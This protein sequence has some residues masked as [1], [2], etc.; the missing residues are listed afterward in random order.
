MDCKFLNHGIAVWYDQTVKPCCAWKPSDEWKTINQ[1]SN[2]NLASWHQTEAVTVEREKL[3]Q[4]QWPTGCRYCNVHESQGR[5]DSVRGNG[6]ISY[7][8]YQG[9]DITLEIRPGSTCN[10]A[11]QTCWPV[12][13]SRVAQ[14][15]YQAGLLDT[16]E[17]N[18]QRLTN[19]DF[20]LPIAKRVKSVTLL[21]GEPFYDKACR[22]FLKWSETHLTAQLTLFTNGSCIDFDFIEKYQGKIIIVFSLDAVG[23]PAEYIRVGTVWDEV[24]SNY[25]KVKK[26]SNVETRINITTS[27]YN[28]NQLENLISWIAQDW[29][30]VVTFGRPME[31]HFSEGAIPI[32]FRNDIIKSLLNTTLILKNAKIESDQKRNAISAIRSIINNLRSLEFNSTAFD[33]WKEFVSKMDNVKGM[34]INDYCPSL[35]LMLNKVS[36]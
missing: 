19:F 23:D 4:D 17:L 9:D 1:V 26:L 25:N 12:A 21:G 24:L 11:C 6:N 13:S 22:E 29:P 2:T 18:N 8:D 28:Y 27:I 7:A 34:S 33:R 20:L 36:A 32:E 14:Y 16:A 30:S 3:E 35:A 5:F 31:P 10:F 15:H